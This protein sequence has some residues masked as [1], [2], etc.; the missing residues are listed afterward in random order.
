MILSSKIRF[1][2]KKIQDVFYE[3]EKG[4]SSEKEL[5]KIINQAMDNL[6]KNVFCEIQI[7]KKLIPEDYKKKFGVENL[8]KYDLPRDWRLIYSIAKDQVLVLSLII[9]WFDHK[10]Y[11]RRFHY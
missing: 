3:L 8:W 2:D 9:E 4:D 1:A 5:F 6:E 11:E 7:P 10:E